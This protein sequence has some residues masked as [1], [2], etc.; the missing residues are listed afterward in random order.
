MVI[1]IFVRHSKGCKYAGDKF[2]RRCNCRKHFRWT[3]NGKQYGRKVGTWS[4]EEAD[5][6]RRELED[7][8]AGRVPEETHDSLPLAQAIETFDANKEA[9]GIKPRVRA[10]YTRELRRLRD[11]SEARTLFTVKQALTIDNLVSFR[12]TWM[13]L[14][15]SSYS[16]SVVQKHLNHFLRFCFNAGWIDRIPKLSPIRVYE[17]ETEPLTEADY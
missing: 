2:C 16:R 10:M 14:Y 6:R 17:P 5:K 11:F 4:W 7:Q 13:A 8:L 15:K 3:Q 12:A 1:T 9:Q